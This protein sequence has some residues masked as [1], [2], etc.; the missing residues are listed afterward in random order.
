MEEAVP[1]EVEL[2]C[3]VTALKVV[4]EVGLQVGGGVLMTVAVWVTGGLVLEGGSDVCGCRAC[5]VC[6]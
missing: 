4:D 1:P 2:A 3:V 5:W 6:E